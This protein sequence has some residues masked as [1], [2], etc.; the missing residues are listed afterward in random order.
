MDEMKRLTR[1]ELNPAG[2]RLGGRRDGGG[3]DWTSQR[4]RGTGEGGGSVRSHYD[5]RSKDVS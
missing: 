4:E 1:V 5:K 2:E 3:G